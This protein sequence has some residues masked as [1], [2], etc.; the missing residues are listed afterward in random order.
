[1]P[2]LLRFSLVG[3]DDCA[4]RSPC[5]RRSVSGVASTVAERRPFGS[6]LG[7]LVALARWTTRVANAG[8]SCRGDGLGAVGHLHLGEDVGHV[9]ADGAFAQE[10]RFGDGVVVASLSKQL[11]HL[12]LAA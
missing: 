1:M 5:L 2:L 4:T 10:Q 3:M 6:V 8:I 7:S 9:V 12:A 11:E